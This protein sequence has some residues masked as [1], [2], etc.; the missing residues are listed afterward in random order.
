MQRQRR[1]VGRL[2]LR[3][4]VLRAP[5]VA[6]APCVSKKTQEEGHVVYINCHTGIYMYVHTCVYIYICISIYVFVCADDVP[7]N[8]HMITYTSKYMCICIYATECS[9]LRS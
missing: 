8:M 1:F 9:V 5:D 2:R 4:R 6:L 7:V 3:Q